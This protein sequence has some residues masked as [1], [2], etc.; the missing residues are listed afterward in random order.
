MKRAE[1]YSPVPVN[2][3]SRQPER[4]RR[5]LAS[6]GEHAYPSRPGSFRGRPGRDAAAGRGTP[7]G[8]IRGRGGAWRAAGS[9]E[10]KKEMK[11]TQ[12]LHNLGQSLWLDNITRD[13]LN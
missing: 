13:L 6:S 7:A 11:A 8:R 12:L 5:N 2:F 1:V 10:R 9:H 4:Q 3:D